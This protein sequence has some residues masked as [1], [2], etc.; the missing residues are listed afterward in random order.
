MCIPH[1]SCTLCVRFCYRGDSIHNDERASMYYKVMESRREV[2]PHNVNI[3]GNID[4]DNETCWKP[5]YAATSRTTSRTL[6][7]PSLGVNKSRRYME[8]HC[9][10]DDA[11]HPPLT[12][13]INQYSHSVLA[14]SRINL[15]T[16]SG[17]YL[18]CIYPLMGLHS[19]NIKVHLFVPRVHASSPFTHEALAGC[20]V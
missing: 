13:F 6:Y 19:S 10:S 17:K 15:P 14:S 12:F 7:S 3:I 20:V 8:L 1:H 9:T 16:A 11:S 2:V 5:I 4:D 18:I